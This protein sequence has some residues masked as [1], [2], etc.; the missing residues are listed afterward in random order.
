MMCDLLTV[1]L[2]PICIA[3][4]E[5]LT[6]HRVE[7]F[8]KHRYVVESRNRVCYYVFESLNGVCR[9]ASLAHKVRVHAA[10]H[11]RV[12]ESCPGDHGLDGERDSG[13]IE[14]SC[15]NLLANDFDHFFADGPYFID[16]NLVGADFSSFVVSS[17]MAMFFIIGEKSECFDAYLKAVM[18]YSASWG[19]GVMKPS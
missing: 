8:Q 7:R 10:W 6:Y 9:L 15:D 16:L 3:A 4:L 19:E 13:E 18:I 14:I 17:L 1:Y 5:G 12:L 11:G 2:S